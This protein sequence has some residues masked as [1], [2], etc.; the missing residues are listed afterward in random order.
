MEEG[1]SVLY[2]TKC[3][4]ICQDSTARCPSCKSQKLRAVNDSDMVLLHRADQYTAQRLA[5]QFDGVGIFYEL[6]PFGKGRV[7]YLYD[8]E[9]MPTD[10]NIYVRYADLPAAKE[11]SAKIKEELEREQEPEDEF[12]DMPRK[13]RMVVQALSVIAFMVLVM[14]AVFGADAFANWLKGLFG[15]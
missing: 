10:K 6:E 12:E 15:M 13:K 2:C 11:L 5:E 4:S 9:I 8:S 3:H 14:L 1:E 7:S